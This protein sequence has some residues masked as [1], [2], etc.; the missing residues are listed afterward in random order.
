FDIVSTWNSGDSEYRTLRGTSMSAP[1]V[2]GAAALVKSA[3][4]SWDNFDLRRALESTARPLP[5]HEGRDRA[6]GH[7]LVRAD[8]ALHAEL[9]AHPRPP[10]AFAVNGSG[11]GVVSANA[12]PTGTANATYLWEWGDGNTSSGPSATHVYAAA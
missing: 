8:A 11:D 6:T 2:A 5:G 9:P 3:H 7:G 10:A 4:P 12:T 1:F